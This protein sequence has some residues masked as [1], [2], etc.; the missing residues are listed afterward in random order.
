M[1]PDGNA[2][3]VSDRATRRER[4][5]T[6]AGSIRGSS[7]VLALL[8]AGGLAV[9]LTTGDWL[10]VAPILGAACGTVGLVLLARHQHGRS[11]G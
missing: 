1:S 11:G 4:D 7:L 9:G 10:F 2:S 6:A 3:R 5:Q 8:L